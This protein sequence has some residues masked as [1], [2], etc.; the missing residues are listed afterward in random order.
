MEL[1][2]A[3][4]PPSPT[5][6]PVEVLV[7]GTG[8]VGGY[9]AAQLAKAGARVSTT[10]RSDL[11]VVREQG[12]HIDALHGP[13]HFRPAQVL[14]E[15]AEFAGSPDYILVALK[16]LEEIPTAELIRP[17]VGAETAILLLQNGVN[18]EEPVA[19]AFPANEL[20]SGLAFVCL[21][22]TAPGHIRHTCYGHLNIGRFPGGPSAAAERLAQLFVA[23]GTPCAV[24]ENIALERW[25]KLVWNAAFNPLSVL[26]QATTR[27]ILDQP[28]SAQLAQQIMTEVCAIA[29]A[30]GFPLGEETV[31][32]NLQATRRMQPYQT[33]MLLDDQAG[34]SMEV[35][36]ILGN[37]VRAGRRHRVATPGLECLYALMSLRVKQSTSGNRPVT[38]Q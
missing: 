21:N 16:V 30:C 35:E 26:G 33:S 6:R 17:A 19:E 13:Q 25:K 28:E 1:D 14:A 23:A 11:M 24:T 4:P 29:T 22:R 36:A 18:I 37:A 32:K 7:V 2:S 27:A 5:H 9:Y 3:S 31:Q 10:H 12:I 20:L 34:R 38:H 8:A 15:V